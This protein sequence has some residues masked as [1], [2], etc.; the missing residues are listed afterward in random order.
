VKRV[1]VTGATGFIGRQVLAPLVAR[2]FDVHAVSREGAAA[3]GVTGHAVDLLQPTEIVRLLGDVRPTHLLHFAWY[4]VPGDYWTSPENV[5]WVEASLSLVRRFAELDGERVVLAG[6]CAEYDW[7]HGFCSETVTP[8]SP[9]TLYG[10]SKDA[11]RRVVEAYS[12]QTGLSTAWGRIFFLYG[13]HERPERLVSSVAR[14]LVNGQPA[15]ATHGRQ[16]R[17]FLH[18]ADVGDA[19]AALLDSD[20]SGPVNVGSGE[21]RTIAEVVF[22]LGQAA[23]RPDLVRLGEIPAPANDPPV[24]LA[25]V[26]RLRDEVGWTPTRTLEQGLRETLEWWQRSLRATGAQ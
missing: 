24:L 14:S 12:P 6:T 21:A 18:V 15:A 3:Q 2:G 4:A 10:A 1:L 9:S 13:P 22:A 17:D 23:G 26:R 11:L 25:D 20:V 8:L 5:R 16:I 7:A 19:F